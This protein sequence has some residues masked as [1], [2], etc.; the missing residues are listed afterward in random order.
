MPASFA[1]AAV[2][3]A[4]WQMH[5][6]VL[7]WGCTAVL[8][9]VISLPALALV[10]WRML[11]VAVL[12]LLTPRT[13][14]ALKGMSADLLMRYMAIGGVVALH[15]LCF[16]GSVKL[17]NASVAATTMALAS[18]FIAF[19]EPWIMRRRFNPA[20]FLLGLV[21]IPGVLLVV[22]GTPPRMHAGLILGVLSAVLVAIFGVLN[23][24]LIAHADALTV[25]CLEMAG[26]WLLISAMLPILPMT[27]AALSWPRGQD[28]WLML[29]LCLACTLLPFAMSLAALRH[30][31]AFGAQ[32]A[33]N[34]E[35][36]YAII[37]GIVLLGEQREL[38]SSFYLGV[39]IILLAIFA[40]PLMQRGIGSPR[41]VH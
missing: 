23:K 33:I 4:W 16:Y 27:A 2:R 32:L 6:C 22:G 38:D 39:V 10:W 28:L 12:L 36:V 41:H 11:L 30:L 34:L 7:L 1:N 40:Y 21:I 37:L 5:A 3:S 8:G 9:K 26:G 31:S 20:E 14:R 24:R 35:P 25:T 17:A 13:W 19:I 15:W 18:V 29:F